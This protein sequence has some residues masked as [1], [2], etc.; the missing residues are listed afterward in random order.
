[1]DILKVVLGA[2]L[3][4]LVLIG[5]SYISFFNRAVSLEEGLTAQWRNNQNSY[6][7]FWKKI[8]E[9]A[10][11]PAQY[12]EDFKEVLLADTSARYGEDGSK[13]MMQ[14][15]QERAVN[16]DSSLYRDLM[17]AIEVGRHDFENHQELLLDKQRSYAS[18]TKSFGGSMFASF[19]GFPREV[20]GELAP[21]SDLDGDG[22]LTVLDYPIVT[23]Q[24][25]K[26]AFT[27]G[28]DGALNV[29]GK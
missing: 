11:V 20:K 15:I 2:A 26:R 22:R 14:W 6:D 1:M 24:K 28:E 12:K 5:V 29:F 10:Q 23:S 27:S 7:A 18:M 16:F 4:G 17:M 25:T 21:P 9:M 8:S 3:V 19:G 13:A